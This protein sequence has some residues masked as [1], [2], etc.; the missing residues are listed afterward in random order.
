MVDVGQKTGGDSVDHHSDGMATA[1]KQIVISTVDGQTFNDD[2]KVI[3]HYELVG[4]VPTCVLSVAF[5]S[6]YASG[7]K[8][9]VD[10]ANSNYQARIF[11]GN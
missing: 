10:I 11:A 9:V 7:A 4:G 1:S 5:H 6:F 3:R 2:T 8:F